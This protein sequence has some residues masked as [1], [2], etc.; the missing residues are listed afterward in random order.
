MSKSNVSITCDNGSIV[1]QDQGGNIQSET[2]TQ[3]AEYLE[4]VAHDLRRGI[5][6]QDND[7]NSSATT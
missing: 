2:P 7:P 3:V 5:P 6:R 4:G 1:I